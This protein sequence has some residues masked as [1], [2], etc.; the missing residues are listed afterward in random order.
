MN[1]FKSVGFGIARSSLILAVSMF[2][3]VSFA[4]VTAPGFVSKPMQVSPITGV[5]DKEA[6]FI[7][8]S[9]EPGASSPRHTHPGDCYGAVLEGTVELFVEGKESKRFDAGQAWHNPRG[10]VHY[11]KNVGNTPARLVNTLI[12]DKGKPRTVVEK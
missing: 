9:M 11:F 3:T 1:S 4:Q 5:E 10:P 2:S 8:V 12:V 7:N 6:A